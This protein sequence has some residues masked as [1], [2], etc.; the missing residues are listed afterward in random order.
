MWDTHG[1]QYQYRKCTY[2]DCNRLQRGTIT[3]LRRQNLQKKH[4]SYAPSA[5]TVESSKKLWGFQGEVGVCVAELLGWVFEA[6]SQ[7]F[8]NLSRR[9]FGFSSNSRWRTS[10]CFSMRAVWRGGIRVGYEKLVRNC[11][12]RHGSE[13]VAS[14][15]CEFQLV[16]VAPE[17]ARMGAA[18]CWSSGLSRHCCTAGLQ[19]LV[20]DGDFRR[21]FRLM[22]PELRFMFWI[23]GGGEDENM[24]HQSLR[25]LSQWD[26]DCLWGCK[27]RLCFVMTGS[28][29]ELLMIFETPCRVGTCGVHDYQWS[30]SLITSC[31]LA[32]HDSLDNAGDHWRESKVYLLQVGNLS[33]SEVARVVGTHRFD[34]GARDG[35]SPRLCLPVIIVANL[36]SVAT[37]TSMYLST[38]QSDLCSPHGAF[39]LTLSFQICTPRTCEWIN[40]YGEMRSIN[41]SR[42]GAWLENVIKGWFQIFS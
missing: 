31:N 19:I 29:N 42:H 23:M 4:E 34:V 10:V 7:V 40:S 9:L 39:G 11:R 22:Y 33:S 36:P 30:S 3:G 17:C 15:A 13:V 38:C 14:P 6:T 26:G 32:S 1:I 41:S 28:I 27:C 25:E 37:S 21:A 35:G 16:C 12:W 18:F 20:S 24:D 5:A 8:D 2:R